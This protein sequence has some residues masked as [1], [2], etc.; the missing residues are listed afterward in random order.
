MS[1]DILFAGELAPGAEP[2]QVR[3]RLQ[4]LFRLTDDAAARLFSGQPLALKRGLDRAQAE[5]LR[6]VFLAAGAVARLVEQPAPASPTAV[7]LSPGRGDP[8]RHPGAAVSAPASLS[9]TSAVGSGNG[10]GTVGIPPDPVPV[11]FLQGSTDPSGPRP[12]TT[13]Q[14]HSSPLTPGSA[15]AENW[16][17]AAV[18]DQPLEPV[19]DHRPPAVDISRLHLV[20]GQDWS[21]ADCDRPPAPEAVPDI[22][23]L[24]LLEQEPE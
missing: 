11:A 9:G 13:S 6:E 3:A 1:Y 4:G 20:A 24:R 7:V 21:L 14:H 16:S 10:S 22:S 18:D 5:R 17:L 12:A 23:H 2:A 15:T 8:E 19:A